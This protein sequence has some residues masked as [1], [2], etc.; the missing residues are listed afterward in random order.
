MPSLDTAKAQSLAR[1]RTGE[2]HAIALTSDGQCLL[3]GH[4]GYGQLGV[5]DK[6]FSSIPLKS[7]CL[8]LLNVRQ[9]SCGRKHTLA[10]TDDDR[11]FACGLNG[12]GQLGLGDTIKKSI[13]VEVTQLE[14]DSETSHSKLVLSHGFGD[15]SAIWSTR[16][17]YKTSCAPDHLCL[18]EIKH[19]IQTIDNNSLPEEDRS[20]AGSL[21]IQKLTKI[22][23]SVA[24]L[25]SSF[26]PNHQT[27]F[28]SVHHPSDAVSDAREA[29]DL[30]LGIQQPKWRESVLTILSNPRVAVHSLPHIGGGISENTAHPECLRGLLF[31]MQNPLLLNLKDYTLLNSRYLSA[32]EK[33]S[34]N[35]W[36]VLKSYWRSCPGLVKH[37]EHFVSA[38]AATLKEWISDR[39]DLHYIQSGLVVLKQLWD[40][41]NLPDNDQ[42]DYITESLRAPEPAA[43]PPPPPATT[44]HSCPHHQHIPVHFDVLPTIGFTINNQEVNIPLPPMTSLSARDTQL[45]NSIAVST[46]PSS[47]TLIPNSNFVILPTA[48]DVMII[49]EEMVK[50][51]FAAQNRGASSDSLFSFCNYPFIFGL[52]GKIQIFDVDRNRF[53]LISQTRAL[54]QHILLGAGANTRQTPFSVIKV[55][56]RHLFQNGKMQI[57][58]LDS[59]G[60]RKP[61]KVIFSGEIGVDDGGLTREFMELFFD[62]VM[63]RTDMFVEVEASSID[64]CE[65][66]ASGAPFVQRGY[67]WFNPASKAKPKDYQTVGRALGLSIFHHCTCVLPF[68]PVLYRRILGWSPALTDLLHFKPSLFRGLQE[69]LQF[70]PS[71]EVADV[72]NLEFNVLTPI[73]H[74]V[75]TAQTMEKFKLVPLP[76]PFANQTVTGENRNEYVEA[77]VRWYTGG[78]VQESLLAFVKGFREVCGGTVLDHFLPAELE[79]FFSGAE[80][81]HVDFKD[82]EA[83]A[84]YKAPFTK[85]HPVIKRFWHV[86][87]KLPLSYKRKFLKFTT[88]TARIPPVSGLRGIILCIQPSGSNS[89]DTSP[90]PPPSPPVSVDPPQVHVEGVD[91]EMLEQGFEELIAQVGAASNSDVAVEQHEEPM[92]TTEDSNA[93]SDSH[94]Q[95]T[96]KRNRSE[97]P[98]PSIDDSSTRSKSTLSPAESS[99]TKTTELPPTKKAK[100][101]QHSHPPGSLKPPLPSQ[102]PASQPSEELKDTTWM[103]DL[104]KSLD[105]PLAAGVEDEQRLL[106]AHTCT[107][108]IDLPW[109]RTV[110]TTAEKLVY[111]LDHGSGQFQLV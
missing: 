27:H 13:F 5:A 17:S 42:V 52:R 86:F 60:L 67:I 19:L 79:L 8:E 9:L 21:L 103:L 96:R 23:T 69:L 73:K 44:G 7:A 62:H 11:I 64:D 34:D 65:G 95:P 110:N 72:F 46:K 94:P 101:S 75:S 57:G 4:G 10:L 51:F 25:N 82:L 30:L 31:L 32:F 78:E 58:K 2:D 20:S 49:P 47:Q 66:S 41:N 84:R 92:D 74:S 40:V 98:E 3:W 63:K 39:Y 99:S 109:Y 76:G 56:R 88:G 107:S 61:L 29:Y 35:Q 22:F 81:A 18:Q 97:S 55:H 77:M 54:A 85:D 93:L 111:A 70:E 28:E 14:Q 45:L 16:T 33:L 91:T 53:M 59:V 38:V 50:L 102:V 43:P 15:L 26:V 83:V 1:D 80:I 104:D 105:D 108:V 12:S 87:H 71:S 106:C 48:D 100:T 24:C 89:L 36:D 68:P 37:F 6:S 90:S